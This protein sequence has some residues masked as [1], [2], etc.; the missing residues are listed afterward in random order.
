M[1]WT[2]DNAEERAEEAPRSFFIPPEDLRRSLKVGDEV[3]LIFHLQ[4]ED[5]EIAVERMWV[6]VV[7]TEPYVGELRN[8][9]QLEGA[10]AFGDRVPFASENVCGYAYSSSELGYDPETPCL[11]LKRVAEA[12]D[13]PPLLLFNDDGQWEAHAEQESDEELADSDSVLVWSLGYLTDRFPETEDAVRE[14]STRR[15]FMCR[16][17]RDTWWRWQTGGYVRIDH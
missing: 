15:G 1:P 6:E 14:G 11:L 3:K 12:D 7:A 9:P 17:Q 2:L 10:I 8:Q 5:G 16:R 13:P 4:R